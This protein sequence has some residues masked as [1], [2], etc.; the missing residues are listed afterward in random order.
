MDHVLAALA[1]LRQLSTFH[2]LGAGSRLPPA[3]QLPGGAWLGSLRHLVAPQALVARSLPAL[4]AAQQLEHV[5]MWGAASAP[6]QVAIMRWAPGCASLRQLDL[7]LDEV[8]GSV[9]EAA[10]QAQQQRRS[11]SVR[12]TGDVWQAGSS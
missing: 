7:Q 11:L 1:G 2:W 10:L 12:C 8:C 6:A 3:A 5:G 4:A 9:L